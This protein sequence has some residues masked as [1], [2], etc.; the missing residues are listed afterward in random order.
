MLGANSASTE[1]LRTAA[2]RRVVPLTLRETEN[3]DLIQLNLLDNTQMTCKAALQNDRF[4]FRVT[5]LWT[6][7]PD[8][9]RKRVGIVFREVVFGSSKLQDVSNNVSECSMRLDD[10]PFSSC[11]GCSPSP[12]I[13]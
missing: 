4:V 12:R 7:G 9:M 8:D 1:P 6:L 11:A 5:E 10:V 3:G 2:G 13:R